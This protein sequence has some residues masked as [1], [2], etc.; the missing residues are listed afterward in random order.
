L[1]VSKPVEPVIKKMRIARVMLAKITVTP[2]RS[3]D[4]LSCRWLGTVSSADYQHS[5]AQ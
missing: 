5:D 1:R 2:T 4:H 3:C